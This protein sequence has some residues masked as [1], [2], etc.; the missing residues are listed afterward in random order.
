MKKYI[1]LLLR[2]G[3][4]IS[5]SCLTSPPTPL[6]RGEESSSL[7]LWERVGVRGT[8]GCS[9]L[10]NVISALILMLLSCGFSSAYAEELKVFASN[11]PL[12]YFAERISGKPEIVFFP[13]IDGDPAFW[14]PVSD[15]ILRIQHADIILLNGAAYEKWYPWVSLPRRKIVDTSKSFQEQYL[16]M[17]E[18]V[19][20]AHGPDGAHSHAG[21]AFTTWLDLNQAAFQANAVKEAMLKRRIAPEGLLTSNFAAL[22]DDLKALDTE[23]HTM[24]QG[25]SKIPLFAS[26]PV[27]HYFA[28]RY[29]L[30]IQAVLWEPGVFPDEPMW[31]HLEELLQEHP[32]QWM[33]WEGAPLPESVARLKEMGV[34]SVVVDPCGNRPQQGD[35]LSVMKQNVE[36][37]KAIFRDK[38]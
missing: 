16:V 1:A 17:Q 21:T 11:Y 36:H 37:L 35:F 18:V 38:V 9:S 26:H 5:S 14:E 19:E 34:E 12:S 22:F 20:H 32:A 28:R 31:Q 8:R 6:L 10:G 23:I 27:Y 2:I 29:G 24:V 15:D 25:H 7:S 13:Q 4:G 33:I 3:I 30:N